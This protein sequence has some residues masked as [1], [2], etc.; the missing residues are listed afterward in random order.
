MNK[1]VQF[2]LKLVDSVSNKAVKIQKS[3]TAVFSSL[4][5]AQHAARTASAHLTNSIDEIKNAISQLQKNRGKLLN[6]D[7]IKLVNAQIAQLQS[8]LRNLE[9]LPPRSFLSNLKNIGS[10]IRQNA[11][12]AVTA[13]IATLGLSTKEILAITANY[14]RMASVLVNTLGSKSE[15]SAS[16]NMISDFAKKTPYGV[17]EVSEA[18][19]KLANRG[20]RATQNQ[21]MGMADVAAVTGKPLE[22]LNEAILDVN[23][24]ERW[25]EFGITTKTKG[26]LV[27]LTFKGVTQTFKRSEEGALNAIVAFGQIPGVMGAIESQGKTLGTQLSNLGDDAGILALTVGEA[28]RP[29]IETVISAI[30]SG[31]SALIGLFNLV[32]QHSTII[33]NMFTI[34]AIAAGAGAVA[35]T[36]YKLA[37]ISAAVANFTFA[38]ALRSVTAAMAAN[39]FTA[40]AV[41]ILAVAMALAVAWEKSETFRG[42]VYALGQTLAAVFDSTLFTDPLK[43]WQNVKAAWGKGFEKGALAAA[44]DQAESKKRSSESIYDRLVKPFGIDQTLTLNNSNQNLHSLSKN[45]SA[46]GTDKSHAPRITTI[47]FGSM[48]FNIKAV[49]KGGDMASLR[50]LAD[51]IAGHI[52]AGLYDVDAQFQN[53]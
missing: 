17:E 6:T 34:V 15:A 18:Y 42:A 36:V 26:D 53:Y 4:L 19:V 30:S 13:M 11:L 2:T 46:S 40:I 28:F 22:Q 29:I 37:A 8:K 49:A 20:I 39:P 31:I 16:L 47:N 1:L 45:T 50:E 10:A 35:Y 7:E 52:A 48:S 32:Y 3:V 25:K 41:A 24:P 43:W 23:N 21:L 14:E 12:P 5:S 9:N 44:K 33:K 38:G 27:S 51:E